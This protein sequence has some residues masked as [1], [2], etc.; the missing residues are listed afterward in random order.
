MFFLK[1]KKKKSFI[2]FIKIHFDHNIKILGSRPKV[3]TLSRLR[4][5]D[6]GTDN[7]IFMFFCCQ[8]PDLR[9]SKYPY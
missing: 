6:E 3:C 2:D 5:K 1:Q 8:S 9:I 7:Q 4:N